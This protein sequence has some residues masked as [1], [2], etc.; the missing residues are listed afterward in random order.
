[1]RSSPDHVTMTTTSPFRVTSNRLD[2]SILL[3]NRKAHTSASRQELRRAKETADGITKR[4]QKD[5]RE[6]M[7]KVFQEIAHSTKQTNRRNFLQFGHSIKQTLNSLKQ[8]IFNLCQPF[9]R[10]TNSPPFM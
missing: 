8:I 6:T 9:L 3:N 1:V 2:S 7:N 10:S 4:A 5:T